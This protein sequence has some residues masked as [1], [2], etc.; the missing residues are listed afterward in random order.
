MFLITFLLYSSFHLRIVLVPI[1]PLFFLTFLNT[2]P[3]FLPLTFLIFILFIHC[4]KHNRNHFIVSHP[5]FPM[6][7]LIHKQ[8]HDLVLLIHISSP[9]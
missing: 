2:L 5:A 1:S 4:L 9:Q 7:Q 3:V 8:C 6:L